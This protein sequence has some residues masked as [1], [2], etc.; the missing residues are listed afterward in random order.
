MKEWATDEIPEN[1]DTSPALIK[2]AQ[3][4]RGEIL[5]TTQRTRPDAAYAAMM[6]ARLTTRWP[7][8]AIQIA[9]KLLCYYNATKDAAFIVKPQQEAKRRDWCCMQMHHIPQL[10]PSQFQDPWYFGREWQFAGER[11]TRV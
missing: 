8:R 4:R 2:E 9:K 3:Q 5:W 6:M 7:E 11:Q 1:V 10:V